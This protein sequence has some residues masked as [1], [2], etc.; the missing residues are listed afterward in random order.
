MMANRHAHVFTGLNSREENTGLSIVP[1]VSQNICFASLFLLKFLSETWQ[2]G[3]LFH[4]QSACE[5][6]RPQFTSSGSLVIAQLKEAKNKN[7]K[8]RFAQ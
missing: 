7:A 4:K 3:Q 8:K 2:D 6:L 1:N 5:K